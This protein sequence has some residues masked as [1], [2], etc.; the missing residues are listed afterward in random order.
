MSESFVHAVNARAADADVSSSHAVEPPCDHAWQTVSAAASFEEILQTNI[1]AWLASNPSL[2]CRS[3]CTMLALRPCA[4]VTLQWL[5]TDALSLPPAQQQFLVAYTAAALDEQVSALTHGASFSTSVAADNHQTELDSTCAAAQRLASLPDTSMRAFILRT[6]RRPLPWLLLQAGTF[7]RSRCG[8]TTFEDPVFLERW[9]E[10]TR[11]WLAAR[12]AEQRAFEESD[13]LGLFQDHEECPKAVRD[14]LPDGDPDD[15]SSWRLVAAGWKAAWAGA[16][17]SALWE[18]LRRVGECLLEPPTADDSDGAAVDITDGGGGHVA[19]AECVNAPSSRATSLPPPFLA[20]V[21]CGDT[22]A[23][24][25]VCRLL[26]GCGRPDALASLDS[27]D[28]SG[29]TDV[30]PLLPSL[31]SKCVHLRELWLRGVT[32]L[33]APSLLSL[34]SLCELE[35]LALGNACRGLDDA[36]LCAFLDALPQTTWHSEARPNQCRRPYGCAS[37]GSPGS[38]FIGASGGGGDP[39]ANGF[40]A[41]SLTCL[42]LRNMYNLSDKALDVVAVRLGGLRELSLHGCRKLTDRGLVALSGG[43]CP[44]LR[45]L[46]ATGAYKMTDGG[47]RCLLSTH[48]ALLL[49]NKPMEFCAHASD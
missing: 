24:S 1:E 7:H 19:A 26:L 18:L 37:G 13:A 9:R 35:V 21:F 33:D 41:A 42:E 44:N 25:D 22:T 46:N 5:A 34:A 20:G 11:A 28:L 23:S 12:W 14:A 27:L 10:S 32:S 45:W 6:I 4:E 43:D 39:T 31:S 2:A 38:V 17:P 40:T 49:Y 47:I 15:L 30:A 3:L 29:V 36:A 48:P 16:L 8:D